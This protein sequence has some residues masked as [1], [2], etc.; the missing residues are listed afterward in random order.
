M[1]TTEKKPP[2]ERYLD[3]E[4][5]VG[6]VW[7]LQDHFRR[8]TARLDVIGVPKWCEGKTLTTEQRIQVLIKAMGWS[9]DKIDW[10]YCLYQ[11]MKE[12]DFED[13]TNYDGE[14]IAMIVAGEL[15]DP[16]DAELK[17]AS[18]SYESIPGWMKAIEKKLR[19]P[20]DVEAFGDEVV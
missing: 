20:S 9:S 17:A 16:H 12:K 18:E 8:I 1:T 15:P 13:V 19:K 10:N 4:H 3:K 7:C 5:A 6:A 11:A 2:I 14:E